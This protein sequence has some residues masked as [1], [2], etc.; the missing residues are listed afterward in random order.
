MSVKSLG[1]EKHYSKYL[2][3]IGSLKLPGCFAMTETNHGSNVK[4][5]ETTAT[6]NHEKRTFT[7]HTHTWRKKYIGNAAVH[8]QMATVLLN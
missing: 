7:I 1:T 8:G 4:G 5:I 2:Q 3:D 6:Y